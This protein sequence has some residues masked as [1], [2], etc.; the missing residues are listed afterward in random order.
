MSTM[1]DV[2]ILKEQGY[3]VQGAT[4]AKG[5]LEPIPEITI[6]ATDR[7]GRQYRVIGV[8]VADAIGPDRVFT[9]GRKITWLPL[10]TMRLQ[11]ADEPK[12]K[13]RGAGFTKGYTPWNK[14]S[15]CK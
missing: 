3:M 2:E 11:I 7:K 13:P 14:S 8:S 6:I 15:G 5:L 1:Q 4:R 9:R 12:G 10:A